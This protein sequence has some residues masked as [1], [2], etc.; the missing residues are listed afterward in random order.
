[1]ETLCDV[2]S[3]SVAM[4]DATTSRHILEK[5]KTTEQ[6][7]NM[8]IYLYKAREGNSSSLK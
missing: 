6:T 2:L 5:I 7:E 3:I 8:K 1:M 4:G